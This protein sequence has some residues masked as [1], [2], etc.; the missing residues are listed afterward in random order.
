MQT[1]AHCSALYT[2]QDKETNRIHTK[3]QN[4][5]HTGTPPDLMDTLPKVLIQRKAKPQLFRL[6][7]KICCPT[8]SLWFPTKCPRALK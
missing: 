3:G 5:Q 1:F 8:N 2:M 4:T 7:V 6:P